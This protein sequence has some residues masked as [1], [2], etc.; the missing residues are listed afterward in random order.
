MKQHWTQKTQKCYLIE[1]ILFYKTLFFNAII[2]IS[3]TFSLVMNKSL[4]VLLINIYTS[5]DA[6]L[7]LSPLL[8]YTMHHLTVLTSTA[9]SPSTF[10]K[11]RWM[12][13]GAI[14][15]C[16][17]EFNDVFVSYTLPCQTPLCQTAPLLPSVTW[18]QNGMGYFWEG[19][20]STGIPPTSASD[21]MCQHNKTRGIISEPQLYLCLK[22]ES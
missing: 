16:V 1:H 17:E 4:H 15:F 19:W 14:F 6:P 21:V 2:T 11:C 12:S 10:S 22:M 7:L 18:Q 3:C 5:R 8:K 20:T 9:W 13:M